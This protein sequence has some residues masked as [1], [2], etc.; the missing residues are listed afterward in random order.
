MCDLQEGGWLAG[1]GSLLA[2]EPLAEVGAVCVATT[3]GDVLL[4]RADAV[5]ATDAGTPQVSAG[6]VRGLENLEPA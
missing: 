5:D 4:W 1:G 2:V 3:T 6:F